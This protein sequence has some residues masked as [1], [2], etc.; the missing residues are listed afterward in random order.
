MG[1]KRERT[2]QYCPRCGLEV[3]TLEIPQGRMA[4]L[5]YEGCRADG[6]P[7]HSVVMGA[8]LWTLCRHRL[9]VAT[10]GEQEIELDPTECACFEPAY[11]PTPDCPLHGYEEDKGMGDD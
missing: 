4:L 6:I 3:A 8:G 7:T 9:P 10:E 11:E 2:G 5:W 1:D